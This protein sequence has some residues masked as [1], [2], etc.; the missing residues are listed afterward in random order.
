VKVS[1]I[2]AVFNR[3]RTI[4]D[5]IQSVQRQTERSQIEYIVVDGNSTDGT[6]DVVR[7]HRAQIDQSI[8][9]PD[10]GIY[11]AL[12]KGIRHATGDIVGFLHADDMLDGDSVIGSIRDLFARGDYDAVYGDLVYVDAEN[13]QRVIRYWR[14]G[15]YRVN[16]FRWGWMP[17]H[18]SVYVRR[19]VY[20][21]FGGYRLDMGS[22]ADYECLVRLMVKQ[23][24]RVGYLPEIVV[25]MRLGGKSNAS[26]ANRIAANRSDREAWLVNG[27][28]PPWGLRFTKPLSKL[29]QYFRRPK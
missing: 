27:L 19:E 6:A 11:D 28:R 12:N 2:T 21:R 9:E 8:R 23:K 17:P 5:A 13:T 18:P 4:A 20:E 25:R 24:I 15:D 22:A 1:I 3:E 7:Q 10:R 14:S 16:R 26:L 29:P